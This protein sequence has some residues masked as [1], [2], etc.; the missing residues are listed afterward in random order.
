MSSQ[1]RRKPDLLRPTGEILASVLSGLGLKGRL[2]ER[3]ALVLWPDVVGEE[4]AHR[5][6]AL[7]I[8]EGVLYVRV[9]S[10]A[11]SQEL[12]FL[13]ATILARFDE[14]LGPGLVKEIRFTRH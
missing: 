3:E 11:W 5:S 1:Q 10:A 6:R 12:H 14:V 4:I 13:K 7:R 9:D 8:K 2:K